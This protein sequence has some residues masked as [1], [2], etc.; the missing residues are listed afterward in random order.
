M[1]TKKYLDLDGLKT[2]DKLIKEYV[3]NE[4][5]KMFATIQ[6]ALE[7]S[8]NL[9]EII[10]KIQI[11]INNQELLNI[12]QQEQIDK[13]TEINETQQYEIDNAEAEEATIDALFK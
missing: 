10:K 6:S 13:N 4:V 11:A 7:N 8:D 12:K 3:N 1:D 5:I 9:E 2:Y